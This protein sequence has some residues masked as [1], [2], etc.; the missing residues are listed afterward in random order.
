MCGLQSEPTVG[1]KNI[2]QAWTVE[3]DAIR[4]FSSH[5]DYTQCTLPP[6]QVTDS[7][8][9]PVWVY[10]VQAWLSYTAHRGRR[11]ICLTHSAGMAAAGQM[12]GWAPAK[13]LQNTKKGDSNWK[14]IEVC[15]TNTKLNYYLFIPPSLTGCYQPKAWIWRI[16][17]ICLHKFDCS[18]TKISYSIWY[19][20]LWKTLTVHAWVKHW[21]NNVSLDLSKKKKRLRWK[22]Q[23]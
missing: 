11:G 4:K 8:V 1:T 14:V 18:G 7:A 19:E 21:E 10:S 17:C 2:Q 3:W 9:S 22:R 16:M 23:N 5:E 13:H 15:L 12:L 6:F 20:C